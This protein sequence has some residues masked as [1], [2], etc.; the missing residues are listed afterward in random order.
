MSQ[1][2]WTNLK[3]RPIRKVLVEGISDCCREAEIAFL[4]TFL[5]KHGIGAALVN[6]RL[7]PHV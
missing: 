1:A 7:A 4:G 3:I 6:Y 5:A 2:F